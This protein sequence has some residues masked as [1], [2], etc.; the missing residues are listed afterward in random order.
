VT[1]GVEL[2]AAAG[3]S[4]EESAAALLSAG[5][6]QARSGLLAEAATVFEQALD[7]AE[8]HGV[9]EVMAD[10]LR[11]LAVIAHHRDEPQRAQELA[12]RSLGLA[13]ESGDTLR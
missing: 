6:A 9:P 12:Q 3:S 10:A 5:E 8:Q 7:L 13:T 4:P 1:A 2:P 11:Q